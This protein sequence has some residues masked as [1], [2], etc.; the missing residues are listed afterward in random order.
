MVAMNSERRILNFIC[1][2]FI[3]CVCSSFQPAA[4]ASAVYH[5]DTDE[6]GIA[7]IWDEIQSLYSDPG[8]PTATA[9]RLIRSLTAGPTS[10]LL[11][12]VFKASSVPVPADFDGFPDRVWIPQ[13]KTAFRPVPQDLDSDGDIEL[14]IDFD[15][16]GSPEGVLKQ[17]EFCPFGTLTVL[18]LDPEGSALPETEIS[19]LSS[20]FTEKAA[21][22][23]SGKTGFKL[24]K[25]RG[26]AALIRLS[27]KSFVPVI[28]N[29]S[30]RLWSENFETA[31]LPRA[32]ADASRFSAE[33]FPNPVRGGSKLTVLFF[34]PHSQNVLLD[35]YDLQWRRVK[36]ALTGHF[37]PG[38]HTASLP[39][40]RDDGSALSRG[41]Y[42]G[43]LRGDQNG[44]TILK[45]GVQ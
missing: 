37:P 9:N 13:M 29:V 19:L 27:R 12:D 15:G 2:V 11:I 36:S 38:N 43:V 24:N 10:L 17:N 39:A 28:K 25:M 41:F 23:E 6:D 3:L 32:G 45:I 22:S 1:K 5:L 20:G 42:W 16:D 21:T 31:A 35:I 26:T 8:K 4:P 7:E 18:A 14:G 33:C 44:K 40:V 34:N 30:L